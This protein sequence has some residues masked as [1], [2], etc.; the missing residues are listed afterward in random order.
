MQTITIPPSEGYELLDSGNGQRLERF[1]AFTVVR[2][3]PAVL[4]KPS[5]P[6]NQAWINPDLIFDEAA[7]SHW[8]HRTGK[9][10]D[11][12]EVSFEAM[13]LLIRPT[14]FRHVGV[15]P[16]QADNWE[17]IGK[18]LKGVKK[19][20]RV[21]NL[22][23]YTGGASIAAAL[24]GAQVTHVD[25]AKGTVHWASEN[26]RRSGLGDA[27]IRWIV[28]D[29]RKFVQREVRRGAT[30]D[31]IVLDPPVFGRG[32]KGEVWRL[33]DSL[34]PLIDDIRQLLSATNLGVV[35][36]MYAT[37]IYPHALA[38]GI[39]QTL[40]GAAG[41]LELSCLM[42]EESESKR[43]LQSGYTLRSR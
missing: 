18:R 30:Y 22:F 35:C 33:E 11:G 13:K 7:E 27:G 40:A 6:Q 17:W 12:W 14:S 4:W 39:E 28:E 21:L 36:N 31:L 41:E 29:A 20:V 38:R 24:A 25:A 23:G 2:P 1:G 37:P 26:A 9:T 43:L 32:T 3:D 5:F 15:F 16:E 10:H 42:L 19:P 34:V 8:R